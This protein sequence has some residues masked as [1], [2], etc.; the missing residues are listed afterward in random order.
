MFGK[1]GS[2]VNDKSRHIDASG[3]FSRDVFLFWIYREFS[4]LH[5]YIIYLYIYLDLNLRL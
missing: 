3:S 5:I 1:K 2:T 4:I